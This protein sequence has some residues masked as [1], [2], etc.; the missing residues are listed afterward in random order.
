MTFLSNDVQDI[1]QM[2]NRQYVDFCQAKLEVRKRLSN[3]LTHSKRSRY[4][5]RESRLFATDQSGK[6][7][8]NVFHV[9]FYMDLLKPTLLPLSSLYVV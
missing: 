9:C 2:F 4:G 5:C 6:S 3:K 8:F 7:H 1:G